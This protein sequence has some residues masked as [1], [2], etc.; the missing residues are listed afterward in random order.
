MMSDNTVPMDPQSELEPVIK[1]LVQGVSNTD[2]ALFSAAVSLKRIADSLDA[3]KSVNAYG[4]GLSEA[5]QN[6]IARGLKGL[7][8]YDQMITP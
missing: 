8:T 7:N 3:N 2:A 6:S 1:W 5:I 4:D